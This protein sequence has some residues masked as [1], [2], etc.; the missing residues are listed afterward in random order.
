[1]TWLDEYLASHEAPED[2]NEGCEGAWDD[3]GDVELARV[4]YDPYAYEMF[5]HLV[6]MT[7]CPWCYAA[8]SQA[9]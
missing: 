2:E 7:L 6:L 3:C 8:R 9:V 4:V 1:M 5:G